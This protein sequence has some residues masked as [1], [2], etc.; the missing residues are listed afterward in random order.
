[1]AEDP[2]T[3]AAAAAAD[4]AAAEDPLAIEAANETVQSPAS[5][6]QKIESR[7]LSFGASP[8]RG[9]M[10]DDDLHQFKALQSMKELCDSGLL[11]E[12]LYQQNVAAI[13]RSTAKIEEWKRAID[14]K[15]GML[16]VYQDD[17]AAYEASVMACGA[18]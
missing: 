14:G 4:A 7:R 13:Q 15:A 11:P 10:A 12:T 16:Q 6:P 8:P 9:G 17:I 1:M 2:P 5:T 3:A 18:Q